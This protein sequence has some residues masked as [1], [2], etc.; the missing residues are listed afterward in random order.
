MG[1]EADGAL[2]LRGDLAVTPLLEVLRLLAA[3]HATGAL[4]IRSTPR[5]LGTGGSDDPDLAAPRRDLDEL[6]IGPRRARSASWRPSYASGRS[7]IS[8]SASPCWSRSRRPVRPRVTNLP[9]EL[10]AASV[11]IIGELLDA[12]SGR[13]TWEPAVSLPDFVEAFGRQVSLTTLALEHARRSCVGHAAARRARAR[14][15]SNPAVQRE[16]RGR[17]ARRRRA[18]RARA[19]RWPDHRPRHRRPRQAAGRPRRRD[20]GPAVRRR[21]DPP[22]RPAHAPR[23]RASW[24]CSTAMRELVAALRARLGRRAHADRGG[25]ARSGAARWPRRSSRPGRPWSWSVSRRSARTCSSTS[26]R[27][28]R[29]TPPSRWSCLLESPNP[30]LAAQM[31][32]AGLHAVIAKPVHVTEIER[33][34]S[35]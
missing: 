4:V 33:L 12:R 3:T 29:A 27:S 10:H 21:S 2:Q 7:A 24:P 16:A 17:A 1:N 9:L 20:P 19:A 26:Y 11:R 32:R 30:P 18:A 22:R 28:S 23:H 14:L 6:R 35:G 8:R 25:R 34:L 5:D 13:F 15:R 31:L